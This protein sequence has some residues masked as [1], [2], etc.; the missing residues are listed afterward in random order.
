MAL[1]M[2]D[3]PYQ[4]SPR[5]TFKI[6]M[7][8]TAALLIVWLAAVIYN[9]T[10]G[11]TFG[12]R[13]ILLMVVALVTTA[14]IDAGVALIKHK[15]G[16]KVL[17]EVV[18]SVVKSYSYVTAIIFTLCCPVYVSYYVIIIGCL[19]STGI[20]HCF[21]GFGRNIF[22]P[23]I[24]G[25]IF[26]GVAFTKAFLIPSEYADVMSSSTVT[27]QYSGLGVKWLSSVLP[28]GFN[29]GNLLLGNY[30][31]AMGET[32]TLLILVLGVILAFRKV[33]NW[34]SSAFYLGTVAIT[35]LFIGFFIP[36]LNPFTY[37]MYHLCLG[38]LMF[39]AIFMI[40][41]PVTSPT[42]PY[43]KALI[44]VI[45][46]LL[47]V[48]IRIDG[49]N[50]EGVMYSIAIIN[51]L[52]PMIDRLVVGRTTDGHAK[53]W[54]TI[55]GLLVASMAINTALSVGA[56]NK[57][58]PGLGNSSSSTSSSVEPTREEKLFAIEGATY[59][60]L[61]TVFADGSN[62]VKAYMAS[63]DGVDTALCYESTKEYSWD[64][65]H[66]DAT[67]NPTLAITFGLADDKVMT[68]TIENGGTNTNFSSSA[69]NFAPNLI[70][71]DAKVLMSMT[72]TSHDGVD[73][74]TG[75]SMSSTAVLEL[76]IESATQYINVDKL[77]YNF[78]VA[79]SYEVSTLAALPA[80]THILNTDVGKVNGAAAVV[81]YELKLDAS[82]D[83][84]HGDAVVDGTVL[85]A[86]NL[87][88][89]KIA[90]AAVTNGGSM[91]NYSDKASQ[92]ASSL[93]GLDATT[94]AAMTEDSHDGVDFV[95][96]ATVSS[97]A[98]LALAAEACA[99]YANDK[100]VA[101][102]GYSAA[103][104]VTTLA[105][106]P[107]DTAI[108]NTYVGKV[109][110]VAKVIG[111]EVKV[112]FSFDT[113]HGDA[114]IDGLFFITV[115]LEDNKI[116]NS[117]LF[118]GGSMKNYSEKASQFASQLVGVD[119]TVLATMSET[120]HDGLDFISGATVSSKEVL[121]LAISVATQYVNDKVV[122]NGGAA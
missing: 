98:I 56:Y 120:S 3:A 42:S 75:A 113:G 67:I 109:D 112:Q 83:T 32:F 17:D 72:S 48:I 38:G 121:K 51:I 69:A 99:Q 91:K 20:K 95:S 73:F 24:I 46:G 65:G 16:A 89:N 47:T 35:A 26:T 28:E 44:G 92:F 108:L 15:K 68:A 122:L 34:R 13:A 76:A 2:N 55:A 4:R 107:S 104:E 9:F 63:V 115:S 103:Y 57:A 77:S 78:G 116:V 39:G 33:I 30:V 43:G 90:G 59:T 8:L 49:N 119:A 102:L 45:A 94:V 66:G 14:I 61:A 64:T 1:K 106:L 117:V 82:W 58:N 62:I 22:N 54:G 6:M 18:N 70:G 85:L 71:L 110:G 10:L 88:D 118:N 53:K 105:E 87:A 86:V 40:T 41:D 25:R 84:G 81:G 19:A 5:T 97:K 31:G 36:G 114:V 111:Y 80:E 37:M 12:V 96:G 74:V 27:T 52:A 79:A 50:P 100:P 101:L 21:G 23:A 93:I 29:M 11:A 7:E 60:E